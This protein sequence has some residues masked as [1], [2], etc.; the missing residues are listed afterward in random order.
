MTVPDSLLVCRDE[1]R[2]AGQVND[3]ALGEF[4]IDLVEAAA[5]CRGKLRAVRGLVRP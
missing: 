3:P 5:D 4:I 1:P 2:L